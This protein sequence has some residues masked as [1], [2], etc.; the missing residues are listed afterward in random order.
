MTRPSRTDKRSRSGAQAQCPVCGKLLR[1]AKG[2]KAHLAQEHSE[3]A[4][5]AKAGVA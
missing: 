4:E 3:P 2:V 5:K 1:G